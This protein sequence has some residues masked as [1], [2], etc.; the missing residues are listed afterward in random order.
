MRVIFMGTPEF[1]VPCLYALHELPNVDVVG[2]VTRRDRPAGRGRALE[3]PPVKRAA[4]DLALQVLQPGSL[5]KPDTQVTL[6]DLAPDIIVVA[7]FGQIL[8][9]DVLTMPQYGCL[10]VHASLLPRYR[11]ASPITAAI[12]DGVAETGNTIMLMDEGLDTGA[13]L[14]QAVL[15][16]AIDDTTASLTARLAQEGAELLARTMPRWIGGEISPQP[17]DDSQATVTRLIRK[18]DGV[19]DW[20]QS[21]AIAE[22]R[23][24]AFTPWP[25]TQTTWDGQILKIIAAHLPSPEELTI[26]S[27][28]NRATPGTVITWG[29]GTSAR[30]GIVCGEH[31]LLVV[32]ALQLAGKRALP[33]TDVIRGQPTLVGAALPS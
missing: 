3:A 1:A 25:G 7:A 13:I 5:R 6:R 21:A 18:E 8:P 24:R 16:I 33:A 28:P 22:R 2:V 11:G 29:R 15:L 14:A 17:Q 20:T 30:V 4:L 32:D 31:S 26:L 12:L 9:P 19:A 27:T 10:N 23:I